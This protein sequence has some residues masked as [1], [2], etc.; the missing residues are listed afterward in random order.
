MKTHDGEDDPPID[1]L[2]D[3]VPGL[4]G[5][6]MEREPTRDLWAGI[7]SRLQA[8]APPAPQRTS[9]V[10]P[11]AAR[12]RRRSW[13][14]MTAAASFAAAVATLTTL[15]L[16]KNLL[17]EPG[18]QAQ[19]M[20]AHAERAVEAPA[21]RKFAHEPLPVVEAQVVPASWQSAPATLRKQNRGL[22]KANLK[23]VSNAETQLR[24]AI[25]EDPQSDYLERLLLTTQDQQ[26]NLHQML[27]KAHR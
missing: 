20:L 21:M 26:Q 3:R 17:S 27:D 5:L 23:L 16:S 15:Q 9:A 8:K 14:P 25:A 19:P 11:R 6:S 2:L 1:R 22:I 7:E 10:T 12:P 24:R 13:L 18:A 4:E